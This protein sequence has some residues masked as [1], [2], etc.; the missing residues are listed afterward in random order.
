MTE[1]HGRGGVDTGGKHGKFNQK[2]RGRGQGE[3]GREGEI[4]ACAIHQVTIRNRNSSTNS[5]EWGC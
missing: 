5:L 4:P 1:A 2:K 3:I